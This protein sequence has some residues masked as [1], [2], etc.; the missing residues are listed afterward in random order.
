MRQNRKKPF[1]ERILQSSRSNKSRIVL[2]IDVN[3]GGPRELTYQA[4]DLLEQTRLSICA[5]KFGR[6]TILKI[7]PERTTQVLKKIHGHGL[8]TI[9]DDK[10]NDID[11]TNA[12]ITRAYLNL[13]F[14][15]MTVNPFAG[16]KGGLE[17]T[18]KLAHE[19]GMGLLALVYMSHPGASEGYG[20]K[21]LMGRSKK[22]QHQ[23]EIFAKKAVEW[24]ADG[25]VVGATRPNIV[26]RVKEILGT[27]V[28]IFSPGVGTQGGE[29]ARSLKAGTDYFIIGRS[30]TKTRNPGKAAA[31]FAKASVVSDD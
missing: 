23:F 20:Q 19:H 18:F 12:A 15:A 6:Q 7:G 25:A 3:D 28:P 10:L 4:I 30:I 29:I 8:T 5:V 17:T 1:K 11:E 9:I 16:W 2:A 27:S 21:V 24:K 31:E 13:G 26:R 14:D 22:T